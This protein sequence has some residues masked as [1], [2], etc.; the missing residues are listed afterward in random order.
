MVA[1]SKLS[2]NFSIQEF[3]PLYMIPNVPRPEVELS[4]ACA[5]FILEPLRSAV[6]DAAIFINTRTLQSR[7]WR[8]EN[9]IQSGIGSAGRKSDHNILTINPFASGA[10]DVNCAGVT[11]LELLTTLASLVESGEIPYTPREVLLEQ[12]G[13]SEWLHIAYPVAFKSFPAFVDACGIRHD[14]LQHKGQAAEP[15]RHIVISKTSAH[16]WAIDKFGRK[17]T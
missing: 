7:G 4:R 11:A 8:G 14:F 12:R 17:I 13:Q 5:E 2:A 16:S 3:F 10:I 1:D 6:G 15:Y 9:Q